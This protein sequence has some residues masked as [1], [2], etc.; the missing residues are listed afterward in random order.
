MWLPQLPAYQM[1]PSL[2]LIRPCG[3]ATRGIGYSFI[4]PVL[5]SR[6]PSRLA[7]CP[8]HHT[9]PSGAASGSCG[10]EPDV[11]VAQMWNLTLTGPSIATGFGRGNSGKAPIR[12]CLI[13]LAWSA[14][15]GAPAFFIMSTVLS[16]S[17]GDLLEVTRL[18]RLWQIVQLSCTS[19]LALPSGS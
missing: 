6:G 19:F 18:R 11:G 16:Q 5:G 13:S 17:S 14:V 4:A 9:V 3:P 12:Y 8:D 15:I 7:N 10:R 1:L 2:S